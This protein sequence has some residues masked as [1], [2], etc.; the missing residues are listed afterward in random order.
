MPILKNVLGLDIGSFS[1]KAVEL[2]KT[3]RG[4]EVAQ[5]QQL[6]RGG[7]T[8]AG[9]RHSGRNGDVVHL[10]PRNVEV[11]EHGKV[12]GH[13]ACELLAGAFLPLQEVQSPLVV[14]A[15]P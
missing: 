12:R 3:L 10:R 11:E 14:E 7:H 5:F 8:R 13:C 4:H 9:P 2:P 15:L 6:E 1:L